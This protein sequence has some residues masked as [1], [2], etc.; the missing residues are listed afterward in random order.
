MGEKEG[1]KQL[2]NY[3]LIIGLF[4]IAFFIIKPIAF[5]LIYGILLAY[6]FYPIYK[7]ALRLFRCPTL[8][9]LAVCTTSLTVLIIIIYLILGSLLSQVVDFYLTLQTINIVNILEQVLPTIISNTD[10]SSILANSVNIS[11]SKILANSATS[12]GDFVLNLPSLILQFFVVL[13]VF[14][15]G[16]RDGEKAFEYFQSLSHLRK[17][18]QNKFFTHFRNITRSV[19]IGEVIVGVVQGLVAGIGYFLFGVPNALLLTIL[20]MV[21]SIIP[22][23]GPWLVWV[24]V[25]IYLFVNGSPNAGLGLLIYGLLLVNWIDAVIRPMIV[26]RN[27][28]INTVIVLIGMIGGLQIFGILG[29]IIGPLTLAY[30]LLV[31]EL[32]RKNLNEPVIFK[33]EEPEKPIKLEKTDKSKNKKK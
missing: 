31:A 1:F 27:T 4:V 8:A 28:E 11:I 26:S 22:I 14:F 32:Y 2:V 33:K 30:V 13:L 25:D 23:V 16:L 6:I 21:V 15:F 19:L 12:L 17:E 10:I 24:P 7:L 20:T 9:A 18:T 29:L 5:A 3:A